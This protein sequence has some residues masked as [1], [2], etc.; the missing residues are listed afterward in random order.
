MNKLVNVSIITYLYY[1]ETQFILTDFSLF[2]ELHHPLPH[3]VI[4]NTTWF[5]P[6][7][8]YC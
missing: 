7:A 8:H 6:K 3:G 4:S 1:S 2:C 5:V